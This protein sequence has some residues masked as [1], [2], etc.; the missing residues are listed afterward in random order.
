MYR[1]ELELEATEKASW[2]RNLGEMCRQINND[3]ICL[4]F[5]L[6]FFYSVAV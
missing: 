4:L 2:F 1:V 5:Y 3:N 6:L